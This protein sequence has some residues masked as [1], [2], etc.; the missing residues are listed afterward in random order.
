MRAVAALLFALVLAGPAPVLGADDRGWQGW[1]FEV[2]AGDKIG[3]FGS[4]TSGACEEF[5][6]EAVSERLD[7][8]IGICLPVTLA[9]EPVGVAVWVVVTSE[10]AFVA[11]PTRDICEDDSTPEPDIRPA[12][13]D[14]PYCRRAWLKLPT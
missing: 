12:G 3:W 5:R 6:R 4:W 9:D 11:S 1:A 8:R 13:L 2:R 14:D 10:Y 7:A